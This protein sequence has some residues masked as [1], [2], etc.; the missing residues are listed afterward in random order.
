MYSVRDLLWGFFA[1]LSSDFLDAAIEYIDR[2]LS[3][4]EG[5]LSIQSAEIFTMLILQ[6]CS[7]K[8]KRKFVSMWSIQCKY[9]K[10]WGIEAREW[11]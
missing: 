8:N 5:R 1:K 10:M 4:N 6:E 9:N 2:K 7:E 11:V 3:L